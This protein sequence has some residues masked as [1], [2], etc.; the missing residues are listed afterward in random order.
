MS[1][2]KQSIRKQAEELASNCLAVRVRLLS[3]LVTT[4]Y[5]KH[6]R[7]YGMTIGQM[8]MLAAIVM[9][10]DDQACAAILARRLCMEKST[11]SR[12]LDRME[13]QGLITRVS[14]NDGRRELL[15][16]TASGR[17]NFAKTYAGWKKAQAESCDVLGNELVETIIGGDILKMGM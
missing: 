6:I 9:I 14:T 16:L 11:V 7:E 4:I 15:R 2:S 8:N 13:E 12:N 10:G 17:R 1:I 5:E 3:R